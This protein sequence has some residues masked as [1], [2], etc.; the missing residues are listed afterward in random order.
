MKFVGISVEFKDVSKTYK[1]TLALNKVNLK[2]EENK[3]YGLLGRNGAGKTTLLKATA[4][5]IM[6]TEGEVEIFNK[7][8]TQDDTGMK[9][10]ALVK[11]K[12]YYFKEMRV[13]TILKHSRM[14]YENWD[15]EF[16][17]EIIKKFNL[18]L[19]KIY[20][21]LSDGYKGVVSIIIG[22]A[23]R[24]PI[25]IFDETYV[26]LDAVNRE[27]FYDILREDYIDNPRTIIISTHYMGEFEGMFEEIILLDEGKL[28]LQE[29]MEDIERKA[30]NI[31][32]NKDIISRIIKNKNII[33]EEALGKYSIISV[34]DDF[35]EK[36]LAQLKQEGIEVSKMPLQKWF[37]NL[38]SSMKGV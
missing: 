38:L 24:A 15:E 2:L 19:N 9:S 7:S 11:D 28:I 27:I 22:L 5:Q 16:E 3:I 34:Y 12:N 1:G 18:P 36:E 29:N 6:P 14:L 8:Y 10:V 33:R 17:K 37:V 13:K 31:K 35:H 20:K 32:G 23:S 30:F 25:T 4:N 26:N 21:K